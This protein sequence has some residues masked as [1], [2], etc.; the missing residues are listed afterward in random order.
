MRDRNIEPYITIAGLGQDA[1]ALATFFEDKFPETVCFDH[2]PMLA[3]EFESLPY[4]NMSCHSD[5]QHA[6]YNADFVFVTTPTR[7]DEVN[8]NLDCGSI[9]EMVRLIR[10][11][12]SSAVIVIISQTD[13]NF[14]LQF[15]E[16]NDDPKIVFATFIAPT[17]MT[18]TIICQDKIELNI[19]AFKLVIGGPTPAAYA[20]QNLV[21]HVEPL[22]S[23]VVT[24][25][26]VVAKAREHAFVQRLAFDL[27]LIDIE[28]DWVGG[29][30]DMEFIYEVLFDWTNDYHFV[31]NS[32]SFSSADVPGVIAQI[33]GKNSLYSHSSLK[34]IKFE[35][36]EDRLRSIFFKAMNQKMEILEMLS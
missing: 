25:P 35:E 31:N 13:R 36:N 18:A 29:T 27:L 33:M 30:P 5:P 10:Q 17:K 6:F 34:V 32:F 24:G 19:P 15:I 21:H 9:T 23:V 28:F 16:Q 20:L 3:Q 2:D 14:I 22:L 11:S 1:C 26:H 7:Y 12:N 4:T 8:K